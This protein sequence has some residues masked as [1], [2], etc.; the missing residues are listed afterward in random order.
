M[1][2]LREILNLSNKIFENYAMA[3]VNEFGG[4]MAK[5]LVHIESVS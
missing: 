3:V 1:G 4:F 2:Q 5:L